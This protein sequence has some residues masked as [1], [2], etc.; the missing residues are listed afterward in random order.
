MSTGD[1]GAGNEDRDDDPAERRA[2]E[3]RHN[4]PRHRRQSCEQ[5]AHRRDLRHCLI[6]D[7]DVRCQFE[8]ALGAGLRGG[9]NGG[10]AEIVA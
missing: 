9:G 4:R 2:E 5:P 8:P 7:R 3:P 10:L 6:F 1:G